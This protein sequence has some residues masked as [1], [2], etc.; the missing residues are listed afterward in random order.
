MIISKINRNGTSANAVAFLTADS[1]TEDF[2]LSLTV[3]L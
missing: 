2:I 3:S 1:S